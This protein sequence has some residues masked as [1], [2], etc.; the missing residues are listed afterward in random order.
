MTIRF[1]GTPI[2]QIDQLCKEEPMVK[3]FINTYAV[4]YHPD[5]TAEVVQTG[6]FGST[7]KS[8]KDLIQFDYEDMKSPTKG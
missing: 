4:E 6:Q 2:E 7:I 5:G 8:S 1:L 3:V